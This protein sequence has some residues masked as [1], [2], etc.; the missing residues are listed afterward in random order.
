MGASRQIRTEPST[1]Q[2]LIRIPRQIVILLNKRDGRIFRSI[3]SFDWKHQYPKYCD[4]ELGLEYQ[5]DYKQ[6]EHEI[7]RFYCRRCIGKRKLDCVP[8]IR[9]RRFPRIVWA[10]NLYLFKVIFVHIQYPSVPKVGMTI[11]DNLLAESLRVEIVMQND[12]F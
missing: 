11:D 3:A 4:P 1:I 8:A 10:W 6:C 7:F 12:K 2:L 5:L 9:F